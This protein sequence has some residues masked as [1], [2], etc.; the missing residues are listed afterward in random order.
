LAA[1]GVLAGAGKEVDP[2]RIVATGIL[3]GSRRRW[4][5][6]VLLRPISHTHDPQNL[7][8]LRCLWAINSAF[9][10]DLAGQVNAEFVGGLRIACGGGQVDFVRAAHASREGSAVIVLPSRSRTGRSRIV[11]ALDAGRAATTSGGDVDYVVTEYGT[12]RLRGRTAEERRAELIA[13][14]HPEDRAVLAQLGASGEAAA[15]LR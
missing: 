15:A 6:E 14:A 3:G 9:E 2:G 7:L 10:V 8:A 1:A 4:G 12:A 11:A 13:I 5:S